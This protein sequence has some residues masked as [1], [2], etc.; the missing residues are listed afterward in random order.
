MTKRIRLTKPQKEELD[1]LANAGVPRL[2]GISYFKIFGES[3]CSTNN[4]VTPLA[5]V[6]FRYFNK[7]KRLYHG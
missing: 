2:S 4:M 1:K 3:L 6:A 5:E 7:Q